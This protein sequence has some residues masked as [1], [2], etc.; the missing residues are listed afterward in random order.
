MAPDPRSSRSSEG[1]DTAVGRAPSTDWPTMG[2]VNDPNT[3]SG[4]PTDLGDPLAA[5]AALRTAEGRAL[6]DEVRDVEPAQELAVATR[7]RR[8]APAP[9]WSRP[10]S[11]RRGCGGGPWRSSAPRT[12][13][14]CSSRRTASSRP[15]APP[16]PR[17]APRASGPGR[18][19]RGRS[20]LR[21]RRRRDRPRPGRD[22][23]PR[24][25]PRPADLRRG[26]RQRGGA[27]AGG[28]DRGARGRRHRG[29]HLR[30]RRGVRGPG[31][32]LRARPRSSTRRPTRR[33]CPG[34]SR[35]P[36]RPRAPR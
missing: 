13:P 32:A 27:G 26:P 35:R 20:V 25:R 34:R 31:A 30:V 16:S 7:L 8:D 10:R 33:P 14:G 29:G 24:R 17:T 19:P 18:P 4:H 36:A 28:P 15:P 6:L 21:H 9:G 12:R 5:F 3:P 23:R 1:S 11:R 22:R 2:R